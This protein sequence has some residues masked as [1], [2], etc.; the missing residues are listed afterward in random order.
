MHTH[1][2]QTWDSEMLDAHAAA[3]SVLY[4]DINCNFNTQYYYEFY[5][6]LFH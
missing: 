6:E 5:I 1:L 2:V 4:K 3:R